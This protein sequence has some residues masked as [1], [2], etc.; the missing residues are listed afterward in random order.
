M[1][2]GERKIFVWSGSTSS[3]EHRRSSRDLVAKL[4]KYEIGEQWPVEEI[5]QGDETRE[6]LITLGVTGTYRSLKKLPELEEY[7]KD[8]S[9]LY[10]D[11]SG[12]LF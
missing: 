12:N 7:D 6:F 3:A 5:D 11:P 1:V 9:I 4:L 2:E 10:Q 8:Y